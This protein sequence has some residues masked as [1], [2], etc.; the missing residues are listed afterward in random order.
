MAQSCFEA[1]SL[2]DASGRWSSLSQRLSPPPDGKWLGVKA[3][4]Y[5]QQT[6]PTVDLYFFNGGYCGVQPAGPDR[7]NVSAMVSSNVASALPA[8]LALHPALQ[9]RSADWQPA[10]DSVATSPLVFCQ[11]A[12]LRAHVL[13][14]GDAAGFVDPFV[15]DGIALALRSGVAAAESLLAFWRA[16]ISLAA[17]CSA[18]RQTYE[19]AFLP[20]FRN[21]RRFR[22]LLAMPAALRAP[23][24]G[25][26]AHTGLPRFVVRS[27][28]GAL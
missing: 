12:P 3:H 1:R 10:T 25:L 18:Y 26:L 28:R 20:V 14:A 15:G 17:A 2:I 24:V 22:R 21:A 19:S 8:V 13:L 4:F 5:E 16:E 6:S 9:R 7:V 23:F 27:T 11:P